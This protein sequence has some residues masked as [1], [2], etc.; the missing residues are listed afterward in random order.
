MKENGNSL[1]VKDSYNKIIVGDVP[2]DSVVL[3]DEL[4]EEGKRKDDPNNIFEQQSFSTSQLSDRTRLFLL[5]KRSPYI[6][7]PALDNMGFILSH[8]NGVNSIDQLTP[9]ELMTAFHSFYRVQQAYE[10]IT[11]IAR[12]VISTNF[13]LNPLFD[14]RLFNRKVHAQSIPDLH[15]HIFSLS[16]K[17]L[18]NVQP[19]C[20]SDLS[21]SLQ[22]S[23]RDPMFQFLRDFI[24][25]P[26][27][28]SRLTTNTSSFGNLELDENEGIKFNFDPSVLSAVSFYR[29]LQYLHTNYV[30]LYNELASLF[31]DQRN[32]DS[33]HMPMLL[34]S[35]VRRRNV[36]EFINSNRISSE[37]VKR[38]MLFLAG[39]LQSGE[40][41]QLDKRV[42]LRG[43]AYT[44]YMTYDPHENQRGLYVAPR[45]ISI[46]NALSALGYYYEKELTIGEA[47][48]QE[49]N[50]RQL[51]IDNYV[52]SH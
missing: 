28:L 27:I 30:N 8:D 36:L 6:A 21:K 42:I 52:S 17:E 5:P 37:A 15:F 34:N 45:V 2:R 41:I 19:I 3:F 24:S 39:H 4:Y 49:R 38:K 7:E 13:H 11:P 44:M 26:G 46:G 43:P 32:F 14:R 29:D 18:R 31:T 20:I 9:H 40:N 48:I 47:W 22:D 35:E 23:M 51:L 12:H 10:E 1:Q 33:T 16:K 50:R 25:E